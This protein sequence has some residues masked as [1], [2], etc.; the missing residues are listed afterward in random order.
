[1]S[2]AFPQPAPGTAAGPGPLTLPAD[3]LR[4]AL[5]VREVTFVPGRESLAVVDSTLSP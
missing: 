5:G 3:R 2:T 1:M 4:E